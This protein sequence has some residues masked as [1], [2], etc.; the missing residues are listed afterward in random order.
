M[1]HDCLQRIAHRCTHNRLR[2]QARDFS[3][4]TK[5]SLTPLPSWVF[6]KNFRKLPKDITD[7][8]CIQL[9]NWD[10]TDPG[11]VLEPD[12][13]INRLDAVA[14]RRCVDWTDHANRQD[15]IALSALIGYSD[16]TRVCA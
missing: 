7:P 6:E 2:P 9:T 13:K 12:D 3:V 8:D 11:E 10:I 15:T 16:S 1:P 14:R 5:H 4:G